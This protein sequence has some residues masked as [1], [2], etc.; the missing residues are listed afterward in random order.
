MDNS[1]RAPGRESSQQQTYG[2]AGAGAAVADRP[3]S[4]AQSPAIANGVSADTPLAGPPAPRNTRRRVLLP[5]LLVVFIAA[6]ILGFR[7][8]RDQALYVSTDNAQVTG[9]LVQIGSLNAGRISAVSVDVG[10]TVTKNEQIATV[11][12]PTQLSVTADG[13]PR[14]GFLGTEDQQVPVTAPMDGVVVQRLG[15][16]GDTVAV[17]QAIVTIV[18]PSRLWVLTQVEETRIGRVQVGQLVTVHIDTLGQDLT[19]RVLAVGRASTASFSL[20]PQ[21]NTSGNYTKVAQL[22]PVKIAV[23]YGRQPLVLGSSVEVKIHVQ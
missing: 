11:T 9:A 10:S 18:D 17:G 12:L 6:I 2:A 20:L 7:Y 8:W 13:T 3:A 15:N 16:P 21:G 1:G 4:P 14:L 5:L 22:V 23:D 19:G